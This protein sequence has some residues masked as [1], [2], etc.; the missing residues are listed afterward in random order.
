MGQW[1]KIAAL[2]MLAALLGVRSIYYWAP[3]V[4]DVV[5]PVAFFAILVSWT[6]TD[7]RRRGHPI[8]LLAGA[9]MF[10]V[11]G[12]AVPGYLIWSR[13]WRGLGLVVLHGLALMVL[14]TV[15]TQVGGYLWFGPA[16]VQMIGGA[17]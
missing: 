13:G 6:L 4:N 12:L 11:A 2:Y 9:P 8:P 10:F 15:V 17:R 14:A 3:S 7:A 16:W 5:I 1:L